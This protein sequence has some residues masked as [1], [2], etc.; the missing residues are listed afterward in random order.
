[1][2]EDKN[3]LDYLFVLVKWRRLIMWPVFAVALVA[4]GIALILPER[5]QAQT[6]LLPSE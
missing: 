6:V 2:S 5:W 4:A 1:M 3:L